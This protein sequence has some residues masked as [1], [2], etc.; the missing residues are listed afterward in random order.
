MSMSSFIRHCTPLGYRFSPTAS[1]AGSKYQPTTSRH[2]ATCRS[3]S[4]HN[5]SVS[6]YGRTAGRRCQRQIFPTCP[7]NSLSKEI[8]KE[9]SHVSCKIFLFRQKPLETVEL[10]GNQFLVILQECRVCLVPEHPALG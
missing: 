7:V 6:S 9:M 4:S 3:S 10:P 8:E 2:S 5:R 1:L